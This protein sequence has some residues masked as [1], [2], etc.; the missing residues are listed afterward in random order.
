MMKDKALPKEDEFRSLKDLIEL[1]LKKIKLPSEFQSLEQFI[2]DGKRSAA[3]IRAISSDETFVIPEKNNELY[4][5]AEM[6]ARHSAVTF[7]VGLV[8]RQFGGLFETI[9]MTVNN[10]NTEKATQMWLTTSLYH[11]KA[12]SSAYIKREDLD[13]NKIFYPFLL[14]DIYDDSRLDCLCHYSHLYPGALAHTYETILNYD[15]YAKE[16]HSTH[17]TDEKRDHGI[18]G[19]VMMFE[20]LVRKAQNQ[21]DLSDLP[22]IKACCLAVAQHN[23]FKSE[24]EEDDA[25]YERYNLHTLLHSSPFKIQKEQSLLLFLSLVDTIEC[26]KKFSKSQNKAKYLE[27]L[28][29]LKQIKIVVTETQIFVDLSGL[30]KEIKKKK[31]DE[32]DKA[33]IAYKKALRGFDNWTILSTESKLEDDLITIHIDGSKRSDSRVLAIAGAI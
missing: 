27:T 31:S 5:V 19:G 10:P 16:Y 3:F 20:E 25:T 11:D 22:A 13:F 17:K 1:E 12:Y 9:P 4:E 28:T 15:E 26:V 6:R 14:T 2:T 7:L 33:F 29:T 23:I 8:F 30:S 18:L 21:N 32:L 24:R